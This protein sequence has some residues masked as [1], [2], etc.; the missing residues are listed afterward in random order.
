MGDGAGRAAQVIIAGIGIGRLDDLL[1]ARPAQRLIAFQRRRAVGIGVKAGGQHPGILDRHD[2]AL[3]KK[4][5]RRMRIADQHPAPV[6]PMRSDGVK[7]N[8]PHADAVHL[9]QP[10]RNRAAEAG[11]GGAQIGRVARRGPSSSC[12]SA[13]ST[14]ATILRSPWPSG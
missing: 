3:R 13:R 11:E 7:R 2:G 4:G 12:H 5:Q 1:A 10:A 6:L 9:R 14:T 8:R